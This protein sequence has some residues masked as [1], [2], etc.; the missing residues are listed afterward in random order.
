MSRDLS[1]SY[2]GERIGSTFSAHRR[3]RTAKK[4]IEDGSSTRVNEYI[5]TG[6]RRCIYFVLYPLLAVIQRG[7]E[8]RVQNLGVAIFYKC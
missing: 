6:G 3:A 2:N 1:V 7:L 4:V 8:F 5:E